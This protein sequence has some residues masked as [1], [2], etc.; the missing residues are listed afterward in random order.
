MR[1]HFKILVHP[2]VGQ[3]PTDHAIVIQD[4]FSSSRRDAT[5]FTLDSSEE[6]ALG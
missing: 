6:F 4:S 5:D 1:Q 2:V 3:P